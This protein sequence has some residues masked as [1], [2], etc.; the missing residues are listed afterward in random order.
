MKKYKVTI[1][2]PVWDD[3]N[4]SVKMLKEFLSDLCGQD[5]DNIL[6]TD[7]HYEIV[8]VVEEN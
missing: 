1:E 5:I 3:E 4:L 6:G 7:A 2:T 8:E